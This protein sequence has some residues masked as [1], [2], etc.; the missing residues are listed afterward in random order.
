MRTMVD[1]CI[2]ILMTNSDLSSV[3]RWAW[4]LK[5][6]LTCNRCSLGTRNRFFYE[7]LSMLAGYFCSTSSL[8]W[9]FECS[10]FHAAYISSIVSIWGTVGNYP[11]FY[12][13]IFASCSSPVGMGNSMRERQWF[14]VKWP[15]LQHYFTA[16]R[17]K[18]IFWMFF[19]I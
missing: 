1:V 15:I 6:Q 12:Y 2:C 8:N 3:I 5:L 7:P 13:Y 19:L 14:H 10:H 11:F 16:C 9:N 17:Q 18:S 4:H